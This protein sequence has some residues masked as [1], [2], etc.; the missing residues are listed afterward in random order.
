MMAI[1]TDAYISIH[2]PLAGRDFAVLPQPKSKKILGFT[3]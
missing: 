2:A 3:I 1:I